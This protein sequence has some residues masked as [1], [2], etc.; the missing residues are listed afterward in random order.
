VPD[1]DE[2]VSIAEREWLK[3]DGMDDAEDCGVGA[4]AESHDEDGDSRE[5]G[6]FEQVPAG[7]FQILEQPQHD[8][9]LLRM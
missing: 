4:N 8:A 9:N 7:E 2:A 1:L 3:K 5:P 6:A